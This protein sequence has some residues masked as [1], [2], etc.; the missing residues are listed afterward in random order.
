MLLVGYGVGY[1]FSGGAGSGPGGVTSGRVTVTTSKQQYGPDETV[2]AVIANGLA[3]RILAMDHQS[4]CTVVAVERR[5]GHT[6]R[7]ENPCRL[8]RPTRLIPL[9]PGSAIT[10]PIRPPGGPGA[11]GWP[12]G[13]YRIAFAY[14]QDPPGQGTT[15][16][17]PSFTV[18]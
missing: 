3:T 16:Y 15:I 8:M 12:P 11:S 14:R 1:G 7:V 5:D 2:E 17:S 10:Q 4:D 6:W 18:A 13:A 9:A